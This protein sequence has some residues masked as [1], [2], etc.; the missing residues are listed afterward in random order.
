MATFI[1]PPITKVT[2]SQ[3][4]EVV[5]TATN[6]TWSIPANVTQLEILA[7]AGGGGGGGG[8]TTGGGGGGAG[9]YIQKLITLNPLDTTL[10]IIVGAGG[11]GGAANTKGTIGANTTVTGNQSA[12]QYILTT[13]GGFGGG[14]VV[15]AIGVAGGAGGCGGGQAGSLA[16]MSSGGGGGIGGPASP[17]GYNPYG[18]GNAQ[19]SWENDANYTAWKANNSVTYSGQPIKWGESGFPGGIC[20]TPDRFIPGVYAHGGI[21]KTVWN[22]SIGGGGGGWAQNNTAEQDTNWSATYGGGKI[23]KGNVNGAAGVA[24][25][26]GGGAGGGAGAVLTTGGAGGSGLVVIRYNA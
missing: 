1:Y 13:G 10:N 6:A 12:T 17:N 18:V 11:A 9:G 8:G 14:G 20:G 15:S 3:L 24:N 4:Y 2:R 16:T 19:L 22:R 21:G 7:I 5:F 23:T 25:T 26:G